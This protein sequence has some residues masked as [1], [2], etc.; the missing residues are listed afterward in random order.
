MAKL[1]QF[2]VY[3][4]YLCF[5]KYKANKITEHCQEEIS[6]V[7]ESARPSWVTS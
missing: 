5:E 6:I 2:K 7:N 1:P 4:L 3:E